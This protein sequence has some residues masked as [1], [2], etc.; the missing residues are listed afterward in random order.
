MFT[1]RAGRIRLVLAAILFPSITLA[2]TPIRDHDIVPEDYFSLATVGECA[3]SPDGRHIAYT[4]SR[5]QGEKEKRN[6]D[7]WIVTTDNKEVR[8][9]TFDPANDVAPQWS[10]DGRFI[11]FLSGRKRAGEEKPPHNGKTQVWRVSADGGEPFPVTRAEKRISAFELAAD[12]KTLYF[13]ISDK[14]VDEEFKELRER[15]GDL[16]YGHGV[17]EYGQVHKLDLVNWRGELVVEP[18]RVIGAISV[19]SDQRRIAML[20]TPDATLLTH[21]G[22]SRIDVY[23]TKSKQTAVVPDGPW[24]ED[25]PTPFGWIDDV[26]FA[27]DGEALAVSVSF[28]GYPTEL[29]VA[30]WEGDELGSRKIERSTDVSVIGGTFDWRP[31]SRDLCFIGEERAR[32]RVYQVRDVRHRGQGPTRVLTPGDVVVGSYSFP[33]RG[34]PLAVVMGTIEHADDVFTVDG[35]RFERLTNVNPQVDTWKLPQISTV[36]WK[37]AGGT[38]VEGILELP[39]DYTPGTPLPMVLEIHGGPTAATMYRFRLWIYGRS[40]M[41][42]RGYALLSPNYRGSTGY[43]DT[44]MTDLIGRENDIDVEDIL[45]GVDA[46]IERGIADP[47][48]LAVMGWS[49]GGFLTNCI[50]TRTDRFK[51]ASSGAGV[52]DMMIQWGIEDTPGHVIN[53][54]EGNLPWENPTEYLESSPSYRLHNVTTPTIIHVGEHDERVPAAHSRTLYRALKHYVK[55]PTELI[56]YPDEGHGLTTRE[57]RKAKMEWDLAWFDKYLIADSDDPPVDKK[58]Q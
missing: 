28:D 12:G 19:S 15:Y 42:A 50:I 2:E 36:T 51:A 44:F 20:T 35:G 49:N 40:I 38:E 14:H 7:L 32:A 33:H 22:W 3:Y 34:E 58:T 16:E 10:P 43:G 6:T 48:R 31:D 5:W 47:N 29:F 55:T 13:V 27:P 41:A 18:K 45:T 57:H 9:L 25:A 24:R 46:M 4:E 17:V 26:K 8:R 39:P 53:F 37:G 52:V 1:F 56:V 54:M 11:Y 23:D 30:E 21:E